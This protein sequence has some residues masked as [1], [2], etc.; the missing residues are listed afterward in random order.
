MRTKILNLI[1]EDCKLT[2]K[3]IAAMAS[4]MKGKVDAIILTG[5]VAYS[6]MM[7]NMLKERVEF[8]APVKV[9]PGEFEMDA[10]AAGALR[11]LEGREEPKSYTGEPVFP[12]FD[13]IYKN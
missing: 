2:A 1:E 5:G 12:G 6:E 3:D 7:V 9:Y 13:V 4:V 11:V 8:I 10:L